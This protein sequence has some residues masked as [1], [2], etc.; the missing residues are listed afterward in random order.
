MQVH[1]SWAGAASQVVVREHAKWVQADHDRIPFVQPPAQEQ[2]SIPNG[3]YSDAAALRAV[4]KGY[5]LSLFKRTP[6]GRSGGDTDCVLSEAFFEVEI[7]EVEE[8]ERSDDGKPE[9]VFKPVE[10]H[11]L[12]ADGRRMV[13]LEGAG[14]SGKTTC[15]KW[16]AQQWE[17]GKLAQFDVVIRAGLVEL[18]GVY[19]WNEWKTVLAVALLKHV[20]KRS[21]AEFEEK[22]SQLRVLWIFD[23]LDEAERL[24]QGQFKDWL[25]RLCDGL[26]GWLP[27]TRRYEFDQCV[28]ITSRPERSSVVRIVEK[29]Q[30]QRGFT[31]V[32][33]KGFLPDSRNRYV[34][35]YFRRNAE[36]AQ[37]VK[38]AL[39]HTEFLREVC[40]TPIMLEVV[41]FLAWR[42]GTSALEGVASTYRLYRAALR[43]LLERGVQRLK[44]ERPDLKETEELAR[45]GLDGPWALALER[46]ATCGRDRHS[47]SQILLLLGESFHSSELTL[48]SG[49]LSSCGWTS[50]EVEEEL[51]KFTHESFREFFLA[52]AWHREVMTQGGTLHVMKQWLKDK[53]RNVM[54]FLSERLALEAGSSAAI[55]ETMVTLFDE[56][57]CRLYQCTGLYP[58]CEL[59]LAEFVHLLL[60]RNP[61]VSANTE[62]G[63]ADGP[64]TP[65]GHALGP[66]HLDVARLLLTPALTTINLFGNSIGEGGAR[67]LAALLI[68][69]TAITEINLMGNSIACEGARSLAAALRVS[70]ALTTLNIGSNDIGEEGARAIADAL[71]TNSILTTLDLTMNKMGDL[72]A[73]H[74]AEALK[75]N[76]HL[77]TLN[78][79]C[80]SI[81]SLGAMRIAEAIKTNS[82]L[83]MLDLSG[84]KFGSD[85]AL[86][87]AEAL[88]TNRCLTTLNLRGTGIRAGG[89]VSIAEA[90]KSNSV[91][92]SLNLGW[93]YM[94]A[95]GAEC[96]ADALKINTTLTTLILD[97]NFDD[98]GAFYIAHALR[99]N[100]TLTT[101]DMSHNRI[102]YVGGQFIADA[103]RTN[104]TL[105]CLN[106]DSN[107]L[108]TVG[109]RAIL[110]ALEMDNLTL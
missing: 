72:G 48:H 80:N 65:L 28:L 83:A 44:E 5:T 26:W 53:Q 8:K 59:G 94:G 27:Q 63:F 109:Q 67:I 93:A 42:S 108:G 90:L 4:Y 17:Q 47:K 30:P 25:A 41:C 23:S 11:D 75:T 88:K 49:I 29:D 95:W 106:L 100:T 7:V 57:Y 19:N 1:P 78:L 13:L 56:H 76:R 39:Q 52:A 51:F 55:L 92:T 70:T 87:F 35:F 32:Q 40:R 21:L 107:P 24:A 110:S 34:D 68:A 54:L 86:L 77:A 96:M 9:V 12:F 3:D 20:S 62:H 16:L 102:G 71:K 2:P 43:G 98:K 45:M 31:R 38:A 105:T 81:C 104:S 85:G 103:L 6:D 36:L 14:G 69:N 89:A 50:G 61:A 101:L 46:L 74:I 58:A 82:V 91:L 64:F 22:R 18:A 15:C 79:T 66:G 60:L 33:L 73:Q 10:L 97:V 99:A 84:N 37:R